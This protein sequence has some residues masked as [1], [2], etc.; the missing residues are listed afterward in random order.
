MTYIHFVSD[1]RGRDGF[2]QDEFARLPKPMQ[3]WFQMDDDGLMKL[4][5]RGMIGTRWLPTERLEVGPPGVMP[6]RCTRKVEAA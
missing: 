1:P 5:Y 6:K 2:F 4:R 3:A